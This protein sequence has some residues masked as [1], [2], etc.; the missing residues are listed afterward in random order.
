[1]IMAHHLAGDG[2]SIIYLIKDIMNALVKKTLTYKPLVLL[3]KNYFL[4]T[5]LSV[6]AKL[7]A[8]YCKRK[9]KNCFFTW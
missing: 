6:P 1:M 4:D 3:K 5:R 9:W 2:K 8:N 7:Y